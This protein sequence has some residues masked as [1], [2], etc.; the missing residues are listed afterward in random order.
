MMSEN[1]TI[2]LYFFT[3]CPKSFLTEKTL[4]ATISGNNFH[5][6]GQNQ[7]GRHCLLTRPQV[8]IKLNKT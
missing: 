1:P 6:V 3:F 4:K 2:L 8:A 7:N 5:F